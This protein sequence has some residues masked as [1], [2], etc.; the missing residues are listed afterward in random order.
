MTEK[1]PE[2]VVDEGRIAGA[3]AGAVVAVVGLVLLIV[4]GQAGDLTAL[5][6]ALE[7]ALTAVM[8]A[9]AV[10]APIWRARKARAEVTPLEDP[11]TIDGEAL[12]VATEPAGRY[13][14]TRTP[15]VAAHAAPEG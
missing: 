6:L 5:H 3:I 15:G 11:R 12:V 10:I 13:V 4:R 1:R 2:P 14:D 7:G 8:A 9:A